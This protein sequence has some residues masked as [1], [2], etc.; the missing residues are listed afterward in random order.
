VLA[1]GQ[2]EGGLGVYWR[3]FWSLWAVMVSWLFAP[4]WFNPLAFD[5]AKTRE[6]LHTWLLWMRRKDSSPVASWEAW[7]AEEHSYLNTGSWNK[8]MHVLAPGVRYAL[9][10]VGLLMALSEHEP[11]Q[12]L[13]VEMQTLLVALGA[14]LGLLLLLLLLRYILRR[15]YLALRI[16][17]TLLFLASV[18]AIPIVLS[19]LSPYK[20]LLLCA[21][22]GYGFAA[23]K[24]VFMAC[25]QPRACIL[26]MQPYDYL[27]GGLLLGLCCLLSVPQ[28]CSKLQTKSLLSAV[29]E[30]H[31]AHNEIMRLLQTNK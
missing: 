7:Y 23:V 28:F 19:S 1:L 3:T 25:G 9:T 24:R 26:I 10:F 2:W 14:L 5:A 18:I 11:G 30:R 16:G 4:F 8:K 13:L 20:L 21:A 27:C 31:I 6:D 15:S 29:F 22:C 17:S 12:S